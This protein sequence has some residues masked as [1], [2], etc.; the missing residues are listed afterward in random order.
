M[1]ICDRVDMT[2]FMSALADG[3]SG[4]GRFAD[5]V[6]DGRISIRWVIVG[7]IAQF[8]IFG[9]IVAQWYISRRRKRITLPIG[10]I[11]V[12]LG[13]F[14]VLL[15]YA[16]IRHD[17]V[18]VVGQMLNIVVALRLIELLSRKTGRPIN[19]GDEEPDFPTVEPDTAE[20]F[21]PRSSENNH[22]PKE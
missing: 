18:F 5:I 9:C 17:I 12:G 16:S 21:L 8:V 15:V 11:Y 6:T 2:H 20:R 10:L 22:E 1:M 14:T 19:D 13:A 4:W 7:L 3:S